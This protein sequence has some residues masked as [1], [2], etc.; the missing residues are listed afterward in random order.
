V[1]G[2]NRDEDIWVKLS[3]CRKLLD[4]DHCSNMM[5][6]EMDDESVG[7]SSYAEYTGQQQQQLLADM[8]LDTSD[9]SSSDQ[10]R[11][12]WTSSR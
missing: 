10:N 3:K 1:K 4:D 9:L 11:P 7:S 8:R 2:S 5:N 6:E 12:R